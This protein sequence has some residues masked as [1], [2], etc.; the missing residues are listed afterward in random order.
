MPSAGKRLSRWILKA[1]LKS[2]IG[3][4]TVGPAMAQSETDLIACELRQSTHSR[5][6]PVNELHQLLNDCACEALRISFDVLAKKRRQSIDVYLDHRDA[7]RMHNHRLAGYAAQQVGHGGD[8]R[9]AE[10]RPFTFKIVR[11]LEEVPSRFAIGWI[12]GKA[13]HASI[14]S[15]YAGRS[16]APVVDIFQES[17]NG[18][19]SASYAPGSVTR[20]PFP[21][22]VAKLPRRGNEFGHY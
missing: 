19:F 13:P 10:A 16:D 20:D 12:F 1:G 22:F 3:E 11:D 15:I 5:R 7:P 8:R 18:F 2:C 9:I 6:R 4:C 14:D 17:I 21:G